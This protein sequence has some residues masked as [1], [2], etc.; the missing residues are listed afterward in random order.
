M[1]KVYNF[2]KDELSHRY[3]SKTFLNLLAWLRFPE[4]QKTPATAFNI[5]LSQLQEPVRN[6]PNNCRLPTFYL[7]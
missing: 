1:L 5:S 3:S 7:S 6:L 4:Y 2:N